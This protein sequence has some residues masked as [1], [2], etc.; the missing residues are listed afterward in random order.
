MTNRIEAKECAEKLQ[1]LGEENRIRIIECLLDGAKN[2][3]ELSK[4]L[5]VEIV[6]VSHHLGVL[7]SAHLVTAKKKG[8][9]VV[10]SL[11][12]DFFNSHVNGDGRS[13]ATHL[14]LGWCK[15][16]IPHK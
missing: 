14:D 2:V 8:R 11:S 1:A 12:S 5:G 16:E 6:N 15:I 3:T 7:R 10:Y 9:F 4:M 13:S